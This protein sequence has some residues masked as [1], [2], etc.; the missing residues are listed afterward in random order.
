MADPDGIYRSETFPGLWLDARA[1]YAE[2][3]QRLIEVLDQGL[4]TPEHA[5]FA[6]KLA[7]ARRRVEG[8]P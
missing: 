1:L 2:D 4:A 7:E 6:A 3:L 8:A 5:A